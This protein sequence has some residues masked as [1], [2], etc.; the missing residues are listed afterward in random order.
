[1]AG[2]IIATNFAKGNIPTRVAAIAISTA[3]ILFFCLFSR[4]INLHRLHMVAE[5]EENIPN[6]KMIVNILA[7]SGLTCFAR[8]R[9]GTSTL[10]MVSIFR[11]IA[12]LRI[13]TASDTSRA[14]NKVPY[15]AIF[16][17]LQEAPSFE[18]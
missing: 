18:K 4:Y 8:Y 13:S 5:D 10:V 15:L 9:V 7:I 2:S 14:P 11:R 1:M 12:V 17:L 3:A 16:K 6:S